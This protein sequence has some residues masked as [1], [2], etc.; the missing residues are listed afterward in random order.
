MILHPGRLTQAVRPDGGQQVGAQLTQNLGDQSCNQQQSCQ[1]MRQ[2][3][4][5][6]GPHP[7]KFPG[8]RVLNTPRR[9]TSSIHSNTPSAGE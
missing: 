8:F 7:G 5:D 6:L 4:H 2:I 1:L 9:V 3:R